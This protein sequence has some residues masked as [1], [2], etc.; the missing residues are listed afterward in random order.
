[1]RRLHLA[2][3]AMLLLLSLPHDAAAGP[4]Y[5]G[6]VADALGDSGGES[7]IVAASI[8]V[9]DSGMTFT[10]QFASGTL[11][12]ATTK[13]SFNVDSDQNSA[14]GAPWNGLGVEFVVSQNY[15]GD[16]G[17]AF[18]NQFG[19]GP[20]ASVPV[21]FFADRV[22]YSFA[23][24]LFGVEDGALDFIAA[25]QTALSV[26]SSTPIY[27]F[28]PDFGSWPGSTTLRV[29]EPSTFAM[30]TGGLSLLFAYRRRSSSRI[31]RG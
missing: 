5:V 8:V 20:N 30:L 28:T 26:N 23:R 24:A 29:P 4:I 17:T 18:L 11:D 12:S 10:M 31:P 2:P 22:E 14:T 3:L 13:S 21:S 6:S 16:T 27:D 15:L 7:D 9:N 25:V 19:A 1:M